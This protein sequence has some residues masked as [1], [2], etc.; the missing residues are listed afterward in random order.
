[1]SE[2]YIHIKGARVNNLKNLEVSIPRDKLI[3]ISGI[4]GSGKSSLAFDTI[5]AEGQRRFVE[6]LS[7]FARQFL[8]RMSKPDVDEISGIPPAIAIEQKVNTRNPRSTVGTNT[9][10]YDYL[11]LLYAKIG[12]TYSPVSGEEVR[13]HSIKDVTDYIFSLEQGSPVFI[14][15]PLG[16]HFKDSRVEKLIG[17]KEEGFTRLFSDGEIIKIDDALKNGIDNSSPVYLL[18]D[19]V[20]MDNSEELKKR[21]GDSLHT[22]FGVNH[23]SGSERGTVLICSGRK[24]EEPKVFST[25]FEADGI[26]FEE[27]TDLLFSF[28]NPIGACPVCSGYGKILGIDEN[29]VVPDPSLS[30]FQEAIACWRGEIMKQFYDDF[31]NNAHL[32][33][34]PI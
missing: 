16:L 2:N 17:V 14:L 29:L 27:P 23:E 20:I 13:R 30:V 6:S 28:N 4:S 5:F 1:M 8:G 19:R 7:S 15:V 34:F 11:R 21:L 25:L 22:A 24:G 10:I 32:F 18:V 12:K 31:I 26:L 3:V 33:D 9:E